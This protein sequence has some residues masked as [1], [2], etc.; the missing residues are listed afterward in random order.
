MADGE[1]I[2]SHYEEIPVVSFCL[3]YLTFQYQC[4]I[5]TDEPKL[6]YVML[7]YMDGCIMYCRKF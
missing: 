2:L 1:K 6:L 4:I 3:S 5:F 7:F